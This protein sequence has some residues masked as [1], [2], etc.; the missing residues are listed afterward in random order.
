MTLK[1]NQ[2]GISPKQF[3][4]EVMWAED[5]DMPSR[6]QAAD[7]LH[8]WIQRGDFCEPDLSYTIQDAHIPIQ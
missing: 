8:K 1:Y 7:A 6:L 4:L 2:Y 3:L 5:V